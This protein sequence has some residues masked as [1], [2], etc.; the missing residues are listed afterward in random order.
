MVYIKLP[1]CFEPKHSFDV[2]NRQLGSGSFFLAVMT[3]H[4]STG[5][6]A[7]TDPLPQYQNVAV[8]QNKY[9]EDKWK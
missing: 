8:E 3:L 6:Q 4:N 7:L 1:I 9:I 2:R 5:A